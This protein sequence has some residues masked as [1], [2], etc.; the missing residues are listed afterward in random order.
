[1]SL[2]EKIQQDFQQALRERKELKVSV[3]RMLKAV[4]F[5]KEKEKRYR[6]VQERREIVVEE[7]KKESPLAKE[8]EKESFLTDEEIIEVISGEIKKRKEAI[9]EFE[10]GKRKDLAEKEKA[11]IEILE[12]YLP[13]Q[14]S[15][16]EIKKLV[17]DKI[18]R[19]GLK[20]V[21]EMGKAM[22]EIM[23]QLKGRADGALV[24]KIVKELLSQAED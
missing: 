16:K 9:L 1:M 10:R 7:L 24:S 20:S 5:N 4:I 12:R 19:L 23:P 14:L 11:E 17:K 3:L 22:K 6:L 18:K 15:E 8:L 2:R 21:K 13:P